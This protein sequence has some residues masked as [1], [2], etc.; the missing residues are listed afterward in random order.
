[1]LLLI[2]CYEII[3]TQ[4][5]N[6]IIMSFFKSLFGSP[7]TESENITLLPAPEF[8]ASIKKSN[9]QVVD[10]RTAIEF[11][12]GHINKAKNID[13]FQK[14]SFKDKLDKLDK[15]KPL[16]LYCRSGQ[17]SKKAAGIAAELGF[18]EIYDLQGGYLAY[19]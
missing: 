15:N 13:F 4:N 6:G 12:S 19:S 18:K 8:K 1:M 14:N 16:H 11:K 3:F 7:T 5:I 9:A 10:V 2:P 17:R